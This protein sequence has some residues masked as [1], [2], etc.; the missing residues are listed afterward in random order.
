MEEKSAKH[1]LNI[2]GAQS[3]VSIAYWRRGTS[4][5]Q[6]SHRVRLAYF[7]TNHLLTGLYKTKS[8]IR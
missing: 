3:L 7:H 4:V 8:E 1:N 2:I 6:F 5:R